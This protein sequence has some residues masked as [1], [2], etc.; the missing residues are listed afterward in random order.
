MKKEKKP[1]KVVELFA[2]VGGFRL[3]LEG[4]GGMSASSLYERELDGSYEVVWSN[5]FEPNASVQHASNVYRY[6]WP[7]SNHSNEN[8]NT[9]A[10]A[11]DLN[12]I[13]P[14]HMIVGGF[15]CQD[16]SVANTL[17]R[18]GGIVGKKGVLWWDIHRILDRLQRDGRPTRYLM[19]E[20]V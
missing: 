14:H 2:G 18:A 19:L 5:Q 12:P 9:I 11:E 15:P 1:I 6:R 7:G 20:N 4:Y 10:N 8:I 3:G 16:Y 13:P 17:K